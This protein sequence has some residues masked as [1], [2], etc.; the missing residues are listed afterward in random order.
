MNLIGASIGETVSLKG[1]EIMPQ[2]KP[3][4]IVAVK[5][6]IIEAIVYEME[7]NSLSGIF[8]YVKDERATFL[9]DGTRAKVIQFTRTDKRNLSCAQVEVLEGDLRGYK[10]RTLLNQDKRDDESIFIIFCS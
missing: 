9:P 10:V 4:A 1:Y 6:H 5:P 8:N 3:V 7:K 2:G